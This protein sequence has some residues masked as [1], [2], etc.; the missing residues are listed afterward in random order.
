VT[1]Y[2]HPRLDVTERDLNA[3]TNPENK[4]S[5]MKLNFN[6]NDVPPAEP[7]VLLERGYYVGEIVGSEPAG[8]R[9]LKLYF[10]LS[11]PVAR[12]LVDFFDPDLTDDAARLSSICRAAGVTVM[13]DTEQLH[14]IPM[15]V[16]VD[17]RSYPQ[18]GIDPYN[19]V[20]SAE[21]YPGCVCCQAPKGPTGDLGAHLDRASKVVETWPE[22]KQCLLG[23]GHTTA[24]A[25]DAVAG[26]AV[27]ELRMRL[28]KELH[29]IANSIHSR[30]RSSE[31]APTD[32]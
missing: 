19:I 8:V 9:S 10:R 18:V 23:G 7:N 21:K 25:G 14:S 13:T 32:F 17:R 1:A 24:T 2:G 27:E 3:A 31:N 16:Y 4:G 6:A 28:A 22:W 15:R 26:D 11:S 5:T 30:S 29:K 12:T 20:A